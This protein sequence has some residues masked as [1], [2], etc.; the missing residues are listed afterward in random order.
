[1]VWNLFDKYWENDK[2]DLRISFPISKKDFLFINGKEPR[3]KW[4]VEFG[5]RTGK[6]YYKGFDSKIDADRY[7]SLYKKN[8]R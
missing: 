3:K 6:I 8:R 2:L 4:I 7:V 1:M 5:K